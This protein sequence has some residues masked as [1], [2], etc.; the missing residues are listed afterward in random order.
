MLYTVTIGSYYLRYSKNNNKSIRAVGAKKILVPEVLC[1]GVSEVLTY[2]KV[3]GGT[4]VPPIVPP[5]VPQVVTNRRYYLKV[6]T[7]GTNR[8]Y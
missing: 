5:I 3:T 1:W 8:R 2:T 6:L 7:E 4:D